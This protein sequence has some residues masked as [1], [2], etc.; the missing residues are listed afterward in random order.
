[1]TPFLMILV[2]AATPPAPTQ[3]APKPPAAE[4]DLA[5]NRL[6][7]FTQRSDLMK[8]G[9][10]PLLCTADQRWCAE[11][12][13]DVDTNASELHVFAGLPNG[14]AALSHPLTKA[15]DEEFALW[16]R[17]MRL[18]DGGLFIGVEH[19]TTTSRS[20]RRL[21]DR[22]RAPAFACESDDPRRIAA[23]QGVGRDVPGDHRARRDDRILAHGDP[24]DDRRAGRDPDVALD[25][26]RLGDDAGAAL[27]GFDRMARGDQADVRPDHHVVADVEPAQVVEGAV[28]VDEDV[29]PDPDV[30]PRSGV[31]RRDQRSRRPPAGRSAR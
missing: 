22:N 7:A 29:A 30:G 23:D 12:S 6:E 21:R 8:Q 25:H 10:P 31:E 9:G 15:D 27:G 3:P 28:L 19:Q 11:I 16:P 20:R 18:A 4:R 5:G 24:A 14:Q 17:L 1:M 2:L 26:D 13:R